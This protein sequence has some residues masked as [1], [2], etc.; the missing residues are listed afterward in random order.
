MS[1]DE[2]HAN[3][4]SGSEILIA[5]AFRQVLLDPQ[6]VADPSNDKVDQVIDRLRL[7]IES[8]HCR[9]NYG[10]RIGQGFHI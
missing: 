3:D 10:S 8:R 1:K 7:V 9:Q 2:F 6:L 5:P 4:L